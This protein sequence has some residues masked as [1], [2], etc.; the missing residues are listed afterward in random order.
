M[1]S[2]PGIGAH[3]H[4]TCWGTH[5]TNSPRYCYLLYLCIYPS[6]TVHQWCL[7][8]QARLLLTWASEFGK[9]PGARVCSNNEAVV[10]ITTTSQEWANVGMNELFRLAA[11]AIEDDKGSPSHSN[12]ALLWAVKGPSFNLRNALEASEVGFVDSLADHLSLQR[13]VREEADNVCS[14]HFAMI[15]KERAV[16]PLIV[17]V[18]VLLEQCLLDLL[19][20]LVGNA[21]A[22]SH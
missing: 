20:M 12:A 14:E 15:P 9:V 16:E 13:L 1:I 3:S 19:A 11:A 4:L 18:L 21:A 6:D 7:A 5:L 8:V 2:M 22:S 10:D 17:V